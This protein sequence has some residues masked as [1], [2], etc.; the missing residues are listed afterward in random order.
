MR[1]TQLLLASGLLASGQVTAESL[2]FERCQIRSGAQAV[3]AECATLAVPENPENPDGKTIDLFVTK[4]LSRSPEPK[5]DAFTVIQG[6]PG[7][8]S[9]DMYIGLR[10]AFRDVL[11]DRDILLVDQRGTGRSNRLSCPLEDAAVTVS[12]DP[13]EM[14]RQAERCLDTLDD[15]PR[16]YTTSVAVQDL[17]AVRKAAGY[18]QLN[19]YGVSYGTR[20][21]QHYLRRFP[22]ATRSL[23]I[24]GVAP[25]EW[26]LAGG[27]IARFSQAAFDS[28]AS[29]CNEDGACRQR[30]GD[31]G[32]KFEVVRQR[33]AEQPIDVTFPD[34]ISG[35]QITETIGESSLVMVARMFPYST[36][37]SALLP[38]IIDSAHSGNFVPLAAQTKMTGDDMAEL[39]A[40]GMHN[41]VVCA[42]DVPFVKRADLRDLD[43]TYIG[44]LMVDGLAAI[45]EVWPKGPIDDDFKQP[46]QS[47]V[48]VL[49]LSGETDPVTPQSNGDLADAMFSNSRHLVVPAHGHGVIMR[50]CVP[51]LAAQFVTDGNFDDL[52]TGCIERERSMPFFFDF[53]GPQP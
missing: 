18:S 45:C 43:N 12:I 4:I 14:R 20:V 44:S 50:G 24:D 19:I 33:L 13:A 21:A 15:D 38:L 48:P 9:I 29:R 11:Q 3:D 7:A 17:E 35:Q 22:E 6:G 30:F 37:Q 28:M 25:V 31:L 39:F 10:Q 52:N 16:Y 5:S 51:Q 53:N 23:I 32:Q 47:D 26:S 40:F 1:I 8:S 27:S 46:F 42:E 2:D 34:P 49:V 36:E 41:S